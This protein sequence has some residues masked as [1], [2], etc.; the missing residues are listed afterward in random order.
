MAK[1]GR[2][3]KENGCGALLWCIRCGQALE[4]LMEGQGVQPGNGLAFFTYGHY[5]SAVFDPMDGSHLEICVCDR[6]LREAGEQGVVH[7]DGELW[8]PY[9]HEGG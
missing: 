3:R 4:N 5:G 9:Y 8:E 7:S 2:P 6:C 1:T